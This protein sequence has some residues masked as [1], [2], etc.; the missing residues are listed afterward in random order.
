MGDPFKDTVELLSLNSVSKGLFGECGL[1]GGYMEAHNIDP[2]AAEM[3]YKLKSIELCSNTIGQAS[4]LLLVDPP[5]K[6]IE[7]DKTVELYEQEK[8]D[9]F[10]GLKERAKLL[11]KTFNAMQN[12]TCSEIQGAMYAFPR[13]H[14]TQKVI[15]EAKKRGV[16]P[17]FLYCLDMV[18]ETGI[19]TVPGS[20]F[21]QKD[22]EYH[23]RITNLVC[24]TE[25]MQVTLDKLVEFNKKFYER[26]A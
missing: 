22:G 12:T 13:I 4:T 21:E 5:T 15:D 16:Q 20:G 2:F 7:S 17:D 6:G 26:Y 18:N 19:M 10:K 24:P 23:F 25:R 8:A 14:L 3:L 1:R 9:I 11:T